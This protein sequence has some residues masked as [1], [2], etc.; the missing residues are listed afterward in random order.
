MV[1]SFNSVSS[2]FLHRVQTSPSNLAYQYPDENDDWQSLTW[3]ETGDKVKEISGGL[4]ALDLS[5]SS[6]VLFFPTQVWTGS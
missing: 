6:D 3:K 4:A 1:A 2:M 5:Q